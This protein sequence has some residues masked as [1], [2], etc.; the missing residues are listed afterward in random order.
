MPDKPKD[1]STVPMTRRARQHYEKQFLTKYKR[2]IKQV[3]NTPLTLLIWGPGESGGA[4][5]QKRLQIRGMLRKLG[6]AAVFSEEVEKKH[7]IPGLSSKAKEL[8]QAC[9]A[10]LIVVLQSSPG[11]IAEVHDFAGLVDIGSKMMIF[12]N[13]EFEAGYSYAGALTELKTEYG[14]V[15]M[16]KYPRDIEQCYLAGKVIERAQVMRHAQWRRRHLN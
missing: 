16:F 13:E 11:S 6:F 12:V 15:H 9:S 4:L 5:Y 1:W 7:P 14:N 8:L 2:Y 3:N 10:D